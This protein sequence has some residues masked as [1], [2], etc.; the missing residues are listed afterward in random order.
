[1]DDNK[2]A[3]KVA[4]VW[5]QALYNTDVGTC[6]ML[7]DLRQTGILIERQNET[8]GAWTTLYDPRPYV[9]LKTPD[10][11]HDNLITAPSGIRG[12][13]VLQAGNEYALVAG[14]QGAA[15]AAI[16]ASLTNPANTSP[17]VQLER[18]QT[19]GDY[20]QVRVNSLYNTVIN[21]YGQINAIIYPTNLPQANA[22]TLGAIIYLSGS[23]NTANFPDGAY[24]GSFIM[25]SGTP[26]YYWARFKGDTGQTGG[27]GAD[28][29]PALM[30]IGS[31]TTRLPN[32]SPT[33]SITPGANN[34]YALNLGL[35]RAV[36][37]SL[38]NTIVRNPNQSPTFAMSP[39]TNGDQ[40]LQAGLPRMF[41]LNV[42]PPSIIPPSGTPSAYI[43]TNA[44]GDKTIGFSINRGQLIVEMKAHQLASTAEPTVDTTTNA[45][46]DLKV[47]LGIPAGASG[48]T[49]S[50]DD[51]LPGIGQAKI[52]SMLILADT[53]TNLPFRIPANSTIDQIS[54]QGYWT[55]FDTNQARVVGAAGTVIDGFTTGNLDIGH[56]SAQ[57]TGNFTYEA[58]TGS[59]FYDADTWVS[60]AQ[61]RAFPQEYGG[62]W[63]WL[64]YRLSRAA[65]ASL[66][67]DFNFRLGR[68]D[69]ASI[70]S[71]QIVDGFYWGGLYTASGNTATQGFYPTVGGAG[72]T[73]N[74]IMSP[75]ADAPELITHVDIYTDLHDGNGA[76]CILYLHYSGAWHLVTPSFEITT[77][78]LSY[79][80]TPTMCDRIAI[81]T[82]N[83]Q[84]S[85]TT[86]RLY[87]AIVS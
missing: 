29:L 81:V 64:T 47:D 53:V 84:M 54:A 21:R 69:W 62:G 31:V 38:A 25:S 72:V 22:N 77:G 24:I 70:E 5:R 20:L 74:D 39:D 46:G 23:A 49:G 79:T 59:F 4:Q 7:Y 73:Q 9:I 34:S 17:I 41:D 28:G 19:N 12:L 65:A 14:Q 52:F 32:Q 27:T 6:F 26:V 58:A 75:L 8:G 60:F 16:L 50:F 83:Y 63:L 68:W 82:T 48:G 36:A 40:V 66:K 2:T 13:T 44:I 86:W 85:D 11:T 67:G 45:A 37:F 30:T 61:H 35:P 56:K 78:F 57:T 87:R 80:F 51:V 71:A 42:Y 10:A 1:M 55:V 76:K 15:G 18:P 33:A 43:D 3:T